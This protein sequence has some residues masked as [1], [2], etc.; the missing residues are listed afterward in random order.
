MASY[1]CDNSE[2]LIKD[3]LL[4]E[5]DHVFCYSCHSHYHIQCSGLSQETYNRKGE[6]SRKQW[7]C[8]W[9]CR[10]SKQKNNLRNPWSKKLQSDKEED[11][12]DTGSNNVNEKLVE[13]GEGNDPNV[14][15]MLKHIESLFNTY[16]LKFEKK[17][18]DVIKSNEFMSDKYDT[19]L[20]LATKNKEKIDTISSQITNINDVVQKLENDN[21]RLALENIE[22]QQYSR[23]E[24]ME[25]LGIPTKEDEN[26]YDLIRDVAVKLGVNLV[27]K[28]ISIA[29][30]I[31]V[32]EGR[33]PPII[34]KFTNRYK[35]EEFIS[36]SRKKKL[37][38][39]EV[40]PDIVDKE[41]QLIC[42]ENLSPHF[43]KLLYL[44]KQKILN[45][46]DFKNPF[47]V[48]NKIVLKKNNDDKF[49][50]VFQTKSDLDKFQLA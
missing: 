8:P 41:L 2:C 35:K 11:I 4:Y 10:E 40:F 9:K 43:K 38:V 46:N 28:D 29:H 17:M 27:I 24:N 44:T 1:V 21:R 7:R 31:P 6:K 22:L 15:I 32:K 5:G 14:N 48:K 50:V 37:K 19:V 45:R 25:I 16:E 42:C 49:C 13:M 33:I 3:Q 39:H 18:D 20:E 23:A 12:E 30:R 26:V 34:V 36:A 47:F